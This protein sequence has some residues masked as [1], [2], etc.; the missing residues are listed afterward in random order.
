[1]QSRI[2]SRAL[3]AVLALSALAAIAPRPADAAPTGYES[4]AFR[5][6]DVLRAARE[7]YGPLATVTAVGDHLY[8]WRAVVY[9]ALLGI[10]MRRA[11]TAQYGASY[12][13]VAVGVHKYD[14]KAVRFADLQ[15]VVLPVM[16]VAS[17]RWY[18]VAGVQTGLARFRS[19]LTATQNWYRAR[20]G[21][22]FRLVQPVVVY[23]PQT[24]AQ[25]RSISESTTTAA[26]RWALLNRSTEAYGANLPAPHSSLRVWIAQYVGNGTDV[27]LG[28]ASVGRFAVGTPRATSVTCPATG[29]LNALCADATYVMGHEGGHAFGLAHP[30]TA[31]D[32]NR[33]I[34]GIAKPW[35]AVLLA[36]EVQGLLGTGFFS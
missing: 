19:V 4:H 36:S 10:D 24:S 28:G 2:R 16:L 13:L 31:A 18:D 3:A 25:W 33:S 35:A 15:R 7:Q 22:T 17:D 1:V 8:S 11:V 5:P 14:W 26:H 9:G 23:T 34:M 21:A 30:T 20:A 12:T 32:M 6:I 29:P 27:W